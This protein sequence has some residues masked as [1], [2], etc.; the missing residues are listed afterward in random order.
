M[1][2]I[3]ITLELEP[4]HAAALHQLC[5]KMGHTDALQYLQ[6]QVSREIRQDQAYDIVHG[7]AALERALERA[8]VNYWPW[9]DTGRAE[10][11]R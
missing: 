9:I 4:N 5:R 6:P 8:H 1:N 2:L 11:I 7:C 10:A 3:T